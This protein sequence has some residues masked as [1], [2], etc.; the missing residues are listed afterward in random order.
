[1]ITDLF[2]SMLM[3]AF[4]LYTLHDAA[5]SNKL[6]KKYSSL[7]FIADW[8]D[9]VCK[10]DDAA[11]SDSQADSSSDSD[12][13]DRADRRRSFWNSP[14]G[15]HIRLARSHETFH[16]LYHAA[17]RYKPYEL[18][19]DEQ[20]RNDL[21]RVCRY[22]GERTIYFCGACKVPLCVGDCCMNFHT[23]D[24]IPARK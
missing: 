8:L 7:D 19:D 5:N 13:C 4:V 3:N 17:S 14:K 24:H 23:L 20:V 1:V 6:P 15:K 9:E 11:A 10:P 2:S 21:R 22:C 12:D 16:C 18:V